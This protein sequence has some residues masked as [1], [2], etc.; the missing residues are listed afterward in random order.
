MVKA[1]ESI[2][3][4][5]LTHVPFCPNPCTVDVGNFKLVKLGNQEMEVSYIFFFVACFLSA[6]VTYLVMDYRTA[7]ERQSAMDK[8]LQADAAVTGTKQKL[9][10]YTKFTD[11]LASAKQALTTHEKALTVSLKREHVHIEKV[12]K[13]ASGTK[14]NA[15]LVL[16]YTGEYAFGMD[17]KAE[18][19]ELN[20]SQSGLEL[21][22]N[23]PVLLGQPK[24]RPSSHAIS[25]V[26]APMDEKAI[27]TEANSK[28]PTLAQQ[29]GAA[30][31][32]EEMIRGLCKL[33]LTE[34]LHDFFAK[35]PGVKQ[36]PAVSVVYK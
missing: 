26:G 25:V 11:Y 24:V 34:F 23:R 2:Y 3:F 28:L 18:S 12:N 6:A 15:L 14:S 22:V 29:H 35:Q 36:A 19:F 27:L 1:L 30:M 17:L 10:G 20:Q 7:S 9:A 33:K 8:V 5:T 32:S 4:A 13:E 21:K 16:N 31:S